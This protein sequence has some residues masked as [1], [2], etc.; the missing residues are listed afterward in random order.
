M[1]TPNTEGDRDDVGSSRQWHGLA[2]GN[3]YIGFVSFVFFAMDWCLDGRGGIH[4]CGSALAGLVLA[5]FATVL[6]E[7]M[8]AGAATGQNRAIHD[9]GRRAEGARISPPV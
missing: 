3:R 5:R 6:T 9:H 7:T 1:T 4:S 8:K 2:W